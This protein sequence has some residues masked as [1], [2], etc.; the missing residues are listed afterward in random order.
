MEEDKPIFLKNLLEF[1]VKLLI[2]TEI[3]SIQFQ[4]LNSMLVTLASE[5]QQGGLTAKR[6]VIHM[7]EATSLLPGVYNV[8]MLSWRQR[9]QEMVHCEGF[10][11][12]QNLKYELKLAEEP[13]TSV[14][15]ASQTKLSNPNSDRLLEFM[16]P[17]FEL[18]WVLVRK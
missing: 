15:V 11:G 16:H 13:A 6:A 8:Q 17:E 2:E 3:D 5:Y 12:S 18:K 9:L 14:S 7:M 10:L 1:G 4:T